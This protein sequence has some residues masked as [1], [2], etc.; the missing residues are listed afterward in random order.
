MQKCVSIVNNPHTVN[1]APILIGIKASLIQLCKQ[2]VVNRTEIYKKRKVCGRVPSVGLKPV[3][4]ANKAYHDLLEDIQ[5]TR[6]S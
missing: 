5:C 2:G 3:Q 6:T 4:I 1:V